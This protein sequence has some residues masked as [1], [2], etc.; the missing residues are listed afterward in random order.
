MNSL[1]NVDWWDGSMESW[2][3]DDMS[4]D[5]SDEYERNG[6]SKESLAAISWK[7]ML[8]LQ[9]D[10]GS[11]PLSK[12]RISYD[13]ASTVVS[14]PRSHTTVLAMMALDSYLKAYE[15]EAR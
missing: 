1:L 9:L 7:T 4:P 11:W 12:T 15:Y 5:Y 13:G 14:P 8:D 10:D 2:W 3:W 6:T